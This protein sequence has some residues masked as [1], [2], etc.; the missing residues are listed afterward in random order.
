MI[1]ELFRL[2]AKEQQALVRDFFINGGKM[3]Q[4]CSTKGCDMQP[5]AESIDKTG[6]SFALE[7]SDKSIQ[8]QLD[9]MIS[10]IGTC[11]EC[12]QLTCRQYHAYALPRYLIIQTTTLPNVTQRVNSKLTLY[13]RYT[14]NPR[15]TI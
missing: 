14:T 15:Q 7:Q 1:D 6:Y 3:A 5:L 8:T 4:M 12:K 13:N 10:A 2:I 11:P 9:A